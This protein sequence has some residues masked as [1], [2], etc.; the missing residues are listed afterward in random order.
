M[1]RT[2][3]NMRLV[4]LVFAVV[5]LAVGVGAWYTSFLPKGALTDKKHTAGTP[6]QAAPSISPAPLSSGS[7]A[8]LNIEHTGSKASEQFT[9]P[10]SWDLVWSYDC[11][12]GPGHLIVSIRDASGQ[13][14]KQNAGLYEIGT[15]GS[16]IQHYGAAGEYSV[17]VK[18]NCSW[19]I[20]AQ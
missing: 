3:R 19:H 6:A 18:S 2:A 13:V 11:G 9:A 7:S 4:L 5:A 15:K 20:T 16:G 10:S 1:T 14:S 8:L 12:G 17:D